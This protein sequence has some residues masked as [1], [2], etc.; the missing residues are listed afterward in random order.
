MISTQMQALSSEMGSVGEGQGLGI[1]IFNILLHD[2]KAHGQVSILGKY[3]PGVLLLKV[4][5]V[6][7]PPISIPQELVRHAESQTPPQTC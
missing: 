7:L 6:D 2:C 3:R 1:C 5:S 4:W